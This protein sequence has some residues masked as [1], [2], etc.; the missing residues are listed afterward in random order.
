MPRR[1]IFTRIHDFSLDLSLCFSFQIFENTG[2]RAVPPFRVI[3]LAGHDV[4][5][6]PQKATKLSKFF[7]ANGSGESPAV[8]YRFLTGIASFLFV[9]RLSFSEGWTVMPGFGGAFEK[10]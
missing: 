8:W 4:A 5:E 2:G 3:G 7:T 6:K 10:N 9:W 1:G